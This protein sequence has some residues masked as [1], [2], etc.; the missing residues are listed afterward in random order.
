MWN[1]RKGKIVKNCTVPAFQKDFHDPF[2][3]CH[4]SDKYKLFSR[5][6]QFPSGINLNEKLYWY[7]GSLQLCKTKQKSS[8]TVYLIFVL[9]RKVLKL[10]LWLSQVD[11]LLQSSRQFKVSTMFFIVVCQEA[12]GRSLF[13]SRT[14]GKWLDRINFTVEWKWKIE[15]PRVGCPRVWQFSGNP[16]LSRTIVPPRIPQRVGNSWKS[17][18]E[19]RTSRNVTLYTL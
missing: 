13:K 8:I 15:A 2:Y 1:V 14:A 11:F 17:G 9:K 4:H 10:V 19:A 5:S 3:L 6:Q 18:S 16:N 12:R 7:F